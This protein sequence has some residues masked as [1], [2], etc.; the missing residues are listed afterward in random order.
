[1][2]LTSVKSTTPTSKLSLDVD[3]DNIDEFHSSQKEI[4]ISEEFSTDPED[5]L[6]EVIKAI[7]HRKI[8]T[9]RSLL[10]DVKLLQRQ[11]PESDLNV[12]EY[13]CTT[14]NRPEFIGEC[15]FIGCNLN[16]VTNFFCLK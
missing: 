14:P 13:L 6:N 9:F 2:E 5:R 4:S 10:V 16:E 11:S 7:K 12:F 3:N 8:N 1:M 15:I